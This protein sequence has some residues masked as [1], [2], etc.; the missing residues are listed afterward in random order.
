MGLIT[1]HTRT[2]LQLYVM[3]PIHTSNRTIGHR[4][5]NAI[6]DSIQNQGTKLSEHF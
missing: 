4:H 6:K 2:Q 1:T 5:H 3:H